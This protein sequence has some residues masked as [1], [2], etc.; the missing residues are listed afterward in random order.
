MI[1]NCKI[2]ILLRD[3]VERAISH[4]FHVARH[5]FE[6]LSLEQAMR[7]ERLRLQNCLTNGDYADPAFR[8]YSYQSRGLH[9]EQIKR[10]Q[11][12]FTADQLLILNSEEL[13]TAP[14]EVLQQ[15]FTFIGVDSKQEI[16]DLQSQNQGSNRQ[17]ITEQVHTQLSE[18]FTEPNMQL[19][20]HIGKDFD[21]K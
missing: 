15:V 7:T 20:T 4:Y 13:I 19:F 5:G 6:N 17:K 2:I 21:W 8:L 12:L 14:K 1:P 11:L 9:L 3:P 18:F 10:Y 16:T